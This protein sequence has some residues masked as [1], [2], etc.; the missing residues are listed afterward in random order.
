MKRAQASLVTA[1]CA[2]LSGT[3]VVKRH[4]EAIGSWRS[5]GAMGPC[6][7]L[8]VVKCTFTCDK[9]SETTAPYMACVPKLTRKHTHCT[10]SAVWG[11]SELIASKLF[12]NSQCDIY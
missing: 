5:E 7:E 3:D 11:R 6:P 8:G 2:G 9:M 12:N 4:D 10:L 1:N